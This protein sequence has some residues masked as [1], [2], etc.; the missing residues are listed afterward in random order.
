M[1]K[2]LTFFVLFFVANSLFAQNTWDGTTITP[3]TH[4]KNIYTITNGA[5]LAWIAQ[6]CNNGS[7]DF[8]VSTVSIAE[9]IDLGNHE[10]TPIGTEEFPFLGN[11]Q[12]NDKVIS[13]LRITGT[14]DNVGLFGFMQSYN[15]RTTLR[16]SNVLLENVNIKGGKHV[17]GLIGY[18]EHCAFDSC[19]VLTG[20]VEGSEA[21]GGF[22]G[23]TLYTACSDCFSN[24]KVT[25]TTNYGGGFVGVNDTSDGMKL[26]VTYCFAKGSVSGPG[27]NGG[28]VGLNNSKVKSAYTVTNPISG[29]TF[30]GFCGENTKLGKFEN[31]YFC[32]SFNSSIQ[33]IGDNKGTVD[34]DLD[35]LGSTNVQMMQ[36]GFVGT[37]SGN[38]LNGSDY[39]KIHWSPDLKTPQ[40]PANER[41]PIPL[42]YYILK[43]DSTASINTLSNTSISIYPNPVKN[44]LFLKLENIHVDK[45]EIV[46]LLGKPVIIPTHIAEM[47]DVSQLNKGIYFVKIYSNDKIHTRKFI[48]Q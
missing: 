32:T 11:C 47:V 21:V 20:T 8:K 19:Y 2:I 29:A 34:V 6:Q 45:V 12:G 40:T 9:D 27:T 28:F 14:N 39:G 35:M 36:D 22:V 33:G 42:W 37:G 24:V 31:C 4:S 46:D 10:W 44:E 25:A 43:Y 23:R 16:V 13:N 48:K 7:L 18:A 15:T 30:G 1:R 5:E 41:H 17:G 3:V 26:I 38:G